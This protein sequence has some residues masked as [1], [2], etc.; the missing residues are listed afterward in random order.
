[1]VGKELDVEIHAIPNPAIASHVRYAKLIIRG[2]TVTPVISY[3]RYRRPL[4]TV[5]FNKTC[6]GRARPCMCYHVSF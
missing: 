5:I 1:M 2:P 6:P 3:S 4:T